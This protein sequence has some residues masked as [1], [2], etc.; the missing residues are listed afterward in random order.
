MSIEY[1]MMAC[2]NLNLKTVFNIYYNS[3]LTWSNEYYGL[4]EG[5]RENHSIKMFNID[6]ENNTCDIYLV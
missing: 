6:T 5:I 4:P 2:G 3:I 1:L